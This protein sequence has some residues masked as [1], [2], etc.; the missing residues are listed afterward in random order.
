METAM[1]NASEYRTPD[2]N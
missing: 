2:W 1:R